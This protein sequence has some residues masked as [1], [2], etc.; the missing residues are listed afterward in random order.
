VS[1]RI[2]TVRS[3]SAEVVSAFNTLQHD[4]GEEPA[5]LVVIFAST[6]QP[7]EALLKYAATTFP[8]AQVIG[9]T[10]A[11]EFTGAE[12]GKGHFV[13]WVLG[14]D[15]VSVTAGLGTGL[16]ADPE[17][18]LTEAIVLREDAERPHVAAILLLDPLSGNGE[19][20][21]LLATTL[22]GPTV[23][24]AGGAAGDDLSFSKTR[25]GCGT[26]VAGDA[27]V[28]ALLHSRKPLGIGVQHGH[29]PLSKR[30]LKVTRAAGATVHEFDGRPALEVWKDEVREAAKA[31][32]VD[33]DELPSSELGPTLL[34]FE[35]GLVAGPDE[36]KIRAPLSATDDGAMSFACGLP[37]G[38]VVRI[39]SSA[40]SDQVDAAR[41]AA[42]KARA[43]LGGEQVAGAL[44][45]DCICRN[46]ILGPLF[47][48]AV[49]EMALALDGAPLAGFETYGEIAMERGQS[50][51]FHNTTTVVLAFPK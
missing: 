19:E 49:H 40:E 32:G 45:F 11:G 44:V 24:L 20:A 12:E 4:L 46:L 37:E 29:R 3:S 26:R 18:A 51:G 25:V 6:E 47:A 36:Y 22:L 7:F 38:A 15:D 42:Q 43:A 14:G 8:A 5:A 28:V 33:V 21:S 9:S 30:P 39:T 16:K 31:E 34:R 50:S 1:L 10:T 27:A 2:A 17:T 48:D 35:A 23:K 41:A 13:A